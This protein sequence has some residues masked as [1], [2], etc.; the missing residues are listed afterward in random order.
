MCV[1]E[2]W[3]SLQQ[4]VEK[5]RDARRTARARKELEQKKRKAAAFRGQTRR[6]YAKGNAGLAIKMESDEENQGDEQEEGTLQV[7]QRQFVDYVR[8]HD[9]VVTTYQ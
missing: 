7:T 9:V 4:G 6:K 2:G 3:K 5:Q 1:Y 8:A